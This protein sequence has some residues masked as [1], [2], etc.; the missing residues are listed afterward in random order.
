MAKV[1]GIDLGTTNSCVSIMEGGEPQV[2]ANA[3][4][5]RTTPSV[6]AF[7]ESGERLV[8]QIAYRQA[9]TN[10][11]NTIFAVKRLMGRKYDDPEVQKAMKVLPYKIVRADNGD[12]WVEIR[13]KRYSPPEISAFILQKMRQTAED[14]LGEKIT[15]AVVTV[16]AYFND[17]QRQATKDAGRVAGLN[18]LRIINEPT[19]ASLSYGLDKKKDEKIAVFDLGG[20]TFDISILEIG[21]GVF[22]VKS[23]N[24]DTFLGGEDFDQR[25]MGYLA[26]EFRKDQG[27]DLRKDRMALQRLKEA[28][29]KAKCELSTSTETTIN[30]P[31]ITADQAGPKHLNMKLTRSKLEALC[32]DLLDKLDGPCVTA[33]RDAGLSASDI[34]EV[35]LVGGMTRMPAVQAHVKKLF[36]KEPHRGVNPDEVVAVG[37]AIQGGVLKGE[38]KDVVLLDVTPLSLG[39]ETLGGVFTKL[40]DKNTTI[41]TKKS[42][43]FSTASDN[44]TAVTIR[45]FQGEREMAADNKLLG[46]FDLIGIPPAPRGLPQIEVSFDIDANGIVHVNAKDLG[47]GKE[48]SIRIT[49]SS[50]LTEQEIKQMVRD[51]ELH[52]AEDHKRREAADA[53]N[54]LDSL[55]YQTEKSLK[56]HGGDLDASTR[57]NIEQAL[58]RAK[59]ELEGQDAAAMKSAAEELTKVSHKLAEAI[60]AKASQQQAGQGP[61]AGAGPGAGETHGD[62]QDRGRKEDVVDADFEEVKGS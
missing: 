57:G 42:Q 44:Q 34:D 33:L 28:A 62:G 7:T 60:Y 30:L 56:E 54:Q 48:Q 52:A 17:S 53:R 29:E 1:I 51:A 49:A 40:I 61:Q 37:A 4:G 58:E 36:G 13:G 18:V 11:D 46:Q 41:P 31:F 35:V 50:G 12:A 21:E 22:E 45:V 10:P 23:T 15:D 20:G 8:G 43:I 3:E 59:K 5:G 16:P 2:I 26:D 24:G 19:A 32:A 47:T 6:V 39:I 55:V 14:Y 9:I 25:L 38:V 27:I